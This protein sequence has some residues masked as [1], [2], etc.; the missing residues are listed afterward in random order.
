MARFQKGQ[1]GNPAGRPKGTGTVKKTREALQKYAPEII[2]KLMEKIRE[3]D[4]GALKL[5]LERLIPVIKET[6]IDSVDLPP[7]VITGFEVVEDKQ[8]VD[9]KRIEW[10]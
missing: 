6:P 10:V 5:A 1:S 7:V 9:E 3:G 2:E 4:P 8:E